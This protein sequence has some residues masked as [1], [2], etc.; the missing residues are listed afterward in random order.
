MLS[1]L[2]GHMAVL[3]ET[4]TEKWTYMFKKLDGELAK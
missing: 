3:V 4:Q 1:E 2:R